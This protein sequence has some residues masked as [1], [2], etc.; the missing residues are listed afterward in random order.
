MLKLKHFKVNPKRTKLVV[1]VQ[2]YQMNLAR[3]VEQAMKNDPDMFT[4]G[5]DTLPSWSKFAKNPVRAKGLWTRMLEATFLGQGNLPE[6]SVDRQTEGDAF[7]SEFQVAMMFL[8]GSMTNSNLQKVV[9]YTEQTLRG[10]Y[11]LE[12][13]GAGK[14]NGKKITNANAERIT[15][16]VIYKAKQENRSVLILSRGMAQRSYSIGEITSLY[17]CYDEGDAGA[18]TQKISRALTP[19]DLNKIGRIY[20]LSFNPNRDDKFDTTILAAAQNIA[21][22]KG[23][24]IDEA[25][26]IVIDTVDLFACTANGRVNIDIDTYLEQ[27]MER[28]SLS[29]MVGQQADM[30]ELSDDEIRLLAAGN[31]NYDRANKAEIAPTGKTGA[32][33]KL[34]NKPRSQMNRDELKLLDKARK[35]LVTIIEH[36][37]HLVSAVGVDSIMECLDYATNNEDYS[38]YITTE[39]GLPPA[40]I[41]ALFD[42]G[43]INYDLASLQKSVKIKMLKVA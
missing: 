10:W 34:A 22:R 23:I 21:K 35:T 25:L 7:D 13:S 26:R 28:N 29:R 37:P 43:I 42:R 20:S 40:S 17:L 1:P 16:E 15:K 14:Y 6:L 4:D 19:D 8:P 32:R 12:I 9:A 41:K 2:F 3:A 30:A 31:S 27:L 11:V 24:E 18:T 38:K 39:F 33:R 36:L 5:T